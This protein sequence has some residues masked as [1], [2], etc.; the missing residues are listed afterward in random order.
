LPAAI[1]EQCGFILVHIL[2]PEFIKEEKSQHYQL[3][4]VGY[5]TSLVAA[6]LHAVEDPGLTNVPPT[7]TKGFPTST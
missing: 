4:A 1:E 6:L 2:G 5:G 3:K 7:F